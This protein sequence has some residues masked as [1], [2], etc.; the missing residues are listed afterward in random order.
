MARPTYEVLAEAWPFLYYPDIRPTGEPYICYALCDAIRAEAITPSE[1]EDAEISIRQELRSLCRGQLWLINA[2]KAAG[3][4][5]TNASVYE[6]DY[7]EFRDAWLR[8]IIAK[9][10]AWISNGPATR[11]AHPAK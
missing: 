9:E 8:Q 7:I 1:Y 10:K 11:T 4:V 2:A 5:R 3:L 6:A